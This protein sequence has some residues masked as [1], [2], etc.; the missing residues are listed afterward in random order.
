MFLVLSCSCLC[1]IHWSHVLSR[2]WRC[3]WS[4]ADRQC[5]IYIWVINNNIAYK[6]ASYIRD[7]MVFAFAIVE[8]K[9]WEPIYP[10]VNTMAA[11]VQATEGSMA[12]AAMAIEII[13][14][15]GSADGRWR[16]IV[17]SSPIGWAHT[18]NYPNID[19]VSQEYSDLGTRTC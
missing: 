18:Q 8:M 1:T 9:W 17:T 7:F 13:L 6:G 3:S 14:G 5:S 10:T 16:C 19:Q 2:E 15:M 12:L 4:S 11:D